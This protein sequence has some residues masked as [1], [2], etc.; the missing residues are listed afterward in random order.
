MN[1]KY[2]DVKT[3]IWSRKEGLSSPCSFSPW[4]LT[5]LALYGC[6]LTNRGFAGPGRE[7]CSWVF[8]A[9]RSMSVF[10]FQRY[11]PS[12]ANICTSVDGSCS[13][14]TLWVIFFILFS[15]SYIPR[16]YLPCLNYGFSLTT[17]LYFFMTDCPRFFPCTTLVHSWIT[18]IVFAS[19]ILLTVL[20][21]YL[22]CFILSW[23]PS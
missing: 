17:H 3:A 13:E 18:C 5:D 8:S 22:S 1:I 4:K 23:Q 12:T 9:W 16:A 19:A 2:K 11:K 6:L 21:L 7:G 15:F 14:K 10:T 20:S